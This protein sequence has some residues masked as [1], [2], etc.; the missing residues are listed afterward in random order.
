M[1][2]TP[3]GPSPGSAEAER[4][5]LGIIIRENEMLFQIRHDL[6]AGDFIEPLH[7]ELWLLLKDLIEGA[8]PVTASTLIHDAQDAVVWGEVR[9][10][11]YIYQLERDAPPGHVV[12]GL[13]K[14]VRELSRRRRLISL[15]DEL[16]RQAVEAPMSISSDEMRNE[17]DIAVAGIFSDAADL[18]LRKLSDISDRVLERLKKKEVEVGLIPPLTGMRTLLGSLLPGRLYMLGGSPGGGKSALLLQTARYIARGGY[19]ALLYSIEMG[20]EEQAVRSLSADTGISSE[21]LER[22]VAEDRDYEKVWTANEM[23]RKTK[24]FIDG[25]SSP[26]MAAIRGRSIRLQKLEGLD[27]LAIDHIH[28]VGKSDRRQGENEALD[29]N[30]KLL[31]A[32]AKDLKIP[33][34]VICQFGTEALR[35][36]AK[37]PHRKPTQG[38]LLYSGV[39]DRHADAILLLHRREYWLHRN[40]PPKNDPKRPEWNTAVD[41]ETGWVDFILAKRRGGKGWGSWR[42]GFDPRTVEFTENRATSGWDGTGGASPEGQLALTGRAS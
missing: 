27:F 37:W 18:G 34:M 13:A 24:L 15:A 2:L 9:A 14:T 26:T 42:G 3:P 28:Y 1:A 32:L 33:V 40:E 21:M 39:I 16:K 6:V 38:D 35:D 12:V 36:M 4:G 8:R 23:E 7:G 22:G 19:T 25:S 20:D 30:L 10:S 17:V 11:E 41:D 29:E 5:L 31:K